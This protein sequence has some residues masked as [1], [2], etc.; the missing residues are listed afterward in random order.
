MTQ[1]ELEELCKEW[2]KRIRLQDWEIS[3]KFVKWHDLEENQ[4]GN[5]GWEVKK[6]IAAIR[7]MA[8]DQFPPECSEPCDIEKTVVHELLHL[9][10]ITWNGDDA[11]SAKCRSEE[12]QCVHI[13][14]CALVDLKRSADKL[15]LNAMKYFNDYDNLKEKHQEQ[16]LNKYPSLQASGYSGP[17]P[18]N[19]E[20]SKS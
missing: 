3:I 13:L 8:E 10:T 15:S 7:I 6:K 20:R 2:Q 18:P 17:I 16:N 9:H 1:L 4:R 12:E 14:S 5:I 19:Y 11:D